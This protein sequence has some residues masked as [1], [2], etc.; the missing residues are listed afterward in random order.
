MKKFNLW[1]NISRCKYIHFKMKFEYLLARIF[2]KMI[3]DEDG[4]RVYWR[5]N[6]YMEDGLMVFNRKTFIFPNPK[7]FAFTDSGPIEIA[8][9]SP[10]QF[11]EVLMK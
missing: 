2:G 6:V 7:F 11:N 5:D 3:D 9:D 10:I 1:L 8:K 4:K